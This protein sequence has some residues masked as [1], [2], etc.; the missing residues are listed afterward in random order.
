M[1]YLNM[2]V[3]VEQGGTGATT[4]A[5]A[6][7]NLGLN[8]VVTSNNGAAIN[9]ASSANTKQLFSIGGTASTATGSSYSGERCQL[10]LSDT[11][12]F[13]WNATQGTT[14]WSAK[15][16]GLQAATN[17]SM[18]FVHLSAANKSITGGAGNNITVSIPYT[19]PTGF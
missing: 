6:R 10:Y 19:I 7:T 12:F 15:I 3:T 9:Y 4:A 1:W 17:D 14:I 8:N 18:R 16:S 13:L 2:P 11:G 5:E